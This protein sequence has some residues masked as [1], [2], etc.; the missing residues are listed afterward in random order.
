MNIDHVVLAVAGFVAL[1]GVALSHWSSPRWL[2]LTVFAG[3]N[4]IRA[5]FSGFCPAA[6]APARLGLKPGSVFR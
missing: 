5:A 4:P 1:L 6:R 3:G 2:P